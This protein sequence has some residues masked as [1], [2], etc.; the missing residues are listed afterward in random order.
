MLSKVFN[1]VWTV[2]PRVALSLAAL[3]LVCGWAYWPTFAA[4]ADK[5]AHD[6][7]YTHGYLVPLFSLFLLWR[8]R[9][10]LAGAMPGWGWWGVLLVSLGAGLRVAAAYVYFDWLDAASLAPC[11]AGFCLLL[12]GRPAL[13]WAWP[14]IAFLFFMIPLPFR[15]ET[16]FGQYLQGVATAASTYF[17]QTVG[18]PALAEGNT[19]LLSHSRVG[20]VEACS[21]LSMLLVFFALA[22][23]VAVVVRRPWLDKAVV[24]L[25]AVPIAVVANVARIT[26]TALAQEWFG[27]EAA[28]DFFHDYAGWMMMPLALGLL[29]LELRMLSWLLVKPPEAAPLAMTPAGPIP[30]AAPREAPQPRKRKAVKRRAAQR[31]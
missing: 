17:L 18:L 29:W 5:W 31:P 30:V 14:A 9:E 21:G 16:A 8:R 23:A 10:L 20:V 6:P 27:P 28:H 2:P 19:I 13:R 15:V 25:S 26:A 7:Q 11:L 1:A 22:T 24:L 3:A 12:G 4:M